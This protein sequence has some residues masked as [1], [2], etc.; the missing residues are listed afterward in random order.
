MH[1]TCASTIEA[2]YSDS[3]GQIRGILSLHRM[4]RYIVLWFTLMRRY[5]QLLH[6]LYC[7]KSISTPFIYRTTLLL[8]P[9]LHIELVSAQDISI[10]I[11]R[12]WKSRHHN[13]Q[14]SFW[15]LTKNLRTFHTDT[16]VQCPGELHNMSIEHICTIVVIRLKHHVSGIWKY[17]LNRVIW[18]HWG[19]CN[20]IRLH[21]LSYYADLIQSKTHSR[22]YWSISYYTDYQI[23]RYQITRSRLY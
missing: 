22:G 18:Y 9:S 7:N 3:P 14:G 1:W 17:S 13:A 2:A 20:D 16:V 4:C 10:H 12:I 23:T 21:R 15:T 19:P 5:K 8:N 11:I 6:V